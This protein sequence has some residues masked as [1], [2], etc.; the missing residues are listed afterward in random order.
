MTTTQLR[1]FADYFQLHVINED[2]EDDLGEAWTH[3]AVSDR[4]AVSERALGIGT[5][6]NVD[7]EV[8][9]ALL[10]HPPGDD[11]LAFDHV[12]EASLQVPSGR[13]A[14]LG[15]TDY[16]PDAA[17]FDVPAG[18]VRVRASRAN[19]EDIPPAIERVHLQIWPAPYSAPAVLKRWSTGD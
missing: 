18:F 4:I 19:P 14:V 16:L 2:A 6:T 12:V 3:E 13:I 17:R 15:C 8:L 10:G 11:T 9:V 1:L 5:E 7:V